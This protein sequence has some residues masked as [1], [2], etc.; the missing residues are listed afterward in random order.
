MLRTLRGRITFSYVAFVMILF[1]LVAALLAREA[2]TFYSRTT[3]DAIASAGNQIRQIAAKNPNASFT[4]LAGDVHSMVE[5]PGL[6]I[7]GF[8][9]PAG[10][11]VGRPP[12]HFGTHAPCTSRF[13][14][15]RLRARC[16]RPHL[17]T[18][19]GH[20]PQTGRCSRSRI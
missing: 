11:S 14:S 15:N 1:L 7:A 3:N 20:P 19:T 13:H 18:A 8:E 9:H 4:T 16:R 6:H 17:L 10:M 12:L 2:V 5:R